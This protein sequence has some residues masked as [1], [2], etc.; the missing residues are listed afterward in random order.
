MKAAAVAPA[1]YLQHSSLCRVVLLLLVQS[2]VNMV[3]NVKPSILRAGPYSHQ[4]VPAEGCC[5]K[6]H[7]VWIPARHT[8][9]SLYNPIQGLLADQH[10]PHSAPAQ[11]RT[12]SS[13]AHAV[14]CADPSTFNM[15]HPYHV[16]TTLQAHKTKRQHAPYKATSA[17]LLLSQV[18]QICVCA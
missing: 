7:T 4:S 6:N 17:S 16:I 3:L 18:L 15:L 8:W 1:A 9:F 13:T 14:Q 5:T 2:D 11:I 12:R 10:L